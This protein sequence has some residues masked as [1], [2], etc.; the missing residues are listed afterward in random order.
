MGSL[1]RD[2]GFPENA[3]GHWQTRVQTDR[4]AETLTP[5]FVA[6]LVETP[7]RQIPREG[8]FWVQGPPSPD[9]TLRRHS[10]PSP[11]KVFAYRTE[12]RLSEEGGNKLMVLDV[13]D[14]GLLDGSTAVHCWELGLVFTPHRLFAIWRPWSS[15]VS[16][17]ARKDNIPVVPPRVALD[18]LTIGTAPLSFHPGSDL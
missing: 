17:S 18:R 1:R 7:E 10:Q 8:E 9:P 5:A 16:P 2:T 6:L 14:L 12:G 3:H 13:V 4:A 11:N 15:E